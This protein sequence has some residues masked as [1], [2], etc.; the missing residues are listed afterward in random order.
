M[1]NRK[2][3]E[4]TDLGTRTAWSFRRTAFLNKEVT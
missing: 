3:S 4:L 2:E 1:P